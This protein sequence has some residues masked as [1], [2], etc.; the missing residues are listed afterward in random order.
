M[1][2]ESDTLMLFDSIK[3]IKYEIQF[4]LKQVKKMNINTEQENSGEKIIS[5]SFTY[6]K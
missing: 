5:F 6:F 4:A 2:P 3:N 1:N